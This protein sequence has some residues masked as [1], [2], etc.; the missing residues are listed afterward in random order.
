MRRFPAR[1]KQQNAPE[2][3][4]ELKYLD[5]KPIESEIARFKRIAG[6]AVRRN[7]HDR[8]LAR[9]HLDDDAERALRLATTP[10]STRSRARCATNIWRS[11]RPD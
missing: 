5:I 10:I 6:T 4:G 7:V 3:Q 9:H 11:T 8:A 2:A 1:S